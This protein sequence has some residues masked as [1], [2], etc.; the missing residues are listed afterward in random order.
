[1]GVCRW[2][3]ISRCSSQD[4]E[5]GRYC[6]RVFV[7]KW[8]EVRVKAYCERRGGWIEEIMNEWSLYSWREAA[9]SNLI[10]PF[11]CFSKSL[12]KPLLIASCMEKT[13][14]RGRKGIISISVLSYLNWELN[15]S[16]DMVHVFWI[17]STVQERHL[18]SNLFWLGYQ[19]WRLMA[20]LLFS[21]RAR[22]FYLP[23]LRANYPMNHVHFSYPIFVTSQEG[24]PKRCAGCRF[25]FKVPRDDQKKSDNRDLASHCTLISESSRQT[26]FV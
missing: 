13:L 16:W 2:I 10:D 8:R 5:A 19:E 15:R 4:L 21:L 9:P 22:L 6:W 26:S 3:C 24:M 17:I 23:E 20:P 18:D 25:G 1:M 11:F 14:N 12:L 7:W